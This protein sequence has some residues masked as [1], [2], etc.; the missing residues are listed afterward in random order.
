MI[1]RMVQVLKKYKKREADGG[2]APLEPAL[3]KNAKNTT[4]DEDYAE[5]PVQKLAKW[6][7]ARRRERRQNKLDKERIRRLDELNFE[8][9]GRALK[10]NRE[11]FASERSERDRAP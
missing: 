2:R 9:D 3:C 7:E 5:V 11:L 10:A 1:R 6:C 8:W 4:W